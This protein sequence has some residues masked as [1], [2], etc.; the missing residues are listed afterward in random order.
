MASRPVVK[1][2]SQKLLRLRGR[3]QRRTQNL[4]NE[5][6]A[7]GIANIWGYRIGCSSPK[8]FKQET[9]VSALTL[10]SLAAFTSIR[11]TRKN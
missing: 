6:G 5:G 8:F 7:A 9:L 3:D 11:K 2:K 1:D 4:T 10:K